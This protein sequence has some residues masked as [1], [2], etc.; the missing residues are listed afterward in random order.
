MNLIDVKILEILG[1][2]FEMSPLSGR[3][4]LARAIEKYKEYQAQ[5][6]NDGFS[7]HV[8]LQCLR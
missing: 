3:I 5:F 4:A 8:F 6:T 1:H 7:L 2:I